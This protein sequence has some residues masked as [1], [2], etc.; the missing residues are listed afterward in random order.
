M[1]GLGLGIRVW[2]LGFRIWGVVSGCRI[3]RLLGFRAGKIANNGESHGP[4]GIGRRV[5]S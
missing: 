5:P 1:K 4:E 2:E 3:W